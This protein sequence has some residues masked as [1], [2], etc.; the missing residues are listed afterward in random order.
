MK[1]F[2]IKLW[3]SIVA[4]L[5]LVARLVWPNLRIDAV[6]LG[7]LV[8]VILAWLSS[9]VKSAEFPGGWKVEFQEVRAAGEKVTQGELLP[10]TAP[11]PRQ[12]RYLDVAR[13]DPNLALVGLRIEIES[14]L[15]QLAEDAGVSSR[16][17]LR[18]MLNDLIDKNVIH[19]AAAE[20]LHELIRAGNE[21]AHGA[22]VDERTANWAL[23]YGPKILSTLETRLSS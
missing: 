9:L 20:G 17:G 23:E 8:V 15:R 16:H 10:S 3:V 11:L 2:R 7:L 21:A 19:P 4:A 14:R 5:L 1:D 13:Q 22:N 6:A 12:L 18:R